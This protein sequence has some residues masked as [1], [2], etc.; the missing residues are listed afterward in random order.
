[1]NAAKALL[2]LQDIDQKLAIRHM[3]YRRIAEQFEAE[4]DL[5]KFQIESE[6]AKVRVLETRLERG[7][8]EAEVAQLK[9]RLA[10]IETRLYGGAITNLRELTALEEEHNISK[11]NLAAAEESVGPAGHAEE[12]AALRY[13]D[14]KQKLIDGEKAW[15]LAVKEL[16]VE[17]KDV[18]KECKELQEIRGSAAAG[19]ESQDMK[20]YTSLLPRKAG[21]AVA[22]VERG[23]CQGCRIKLPI[24]EIA[25]LKSSD[26]LVVCS[27]CGRILLAE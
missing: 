23:I 12:E 7:R 1:L 26:S 3:A 17:A 8:L 2:E 22:R 25:R 13:E 18:S 10:S 14:L 9:E 20:L 4:G 15:K 6:S 21:V 19:I 11:R 24:R 27:S 5:K 16:R